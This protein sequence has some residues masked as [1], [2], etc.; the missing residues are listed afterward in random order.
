MSIRMYTVCTR[1]FTLSFPI[2]FF[3]VFRG[4][5]NMDDCV[6]AMYVHHLMWFCEIKVVTREEFEADL[7]N[8]VTATC[9]N[10]QIT[11][12]LLFCM[13]LAVS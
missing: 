5:K 10:H 4:E 1:F 2:T 6:D 11:T 12:H 3:A 7:L 13:K 8:D 9:Y